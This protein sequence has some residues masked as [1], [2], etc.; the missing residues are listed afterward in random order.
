MRILAINGG[1]TAGYAAVLLL[2]Q[3][4]QRI[5]TPCHRAFDL[6]AGVSTGSIVAAALGLG[7]PASALATLYRTK[8]PSIFKKPFW[9]PWRWYVGQP[10]YRTSRLT[11]VLSRTFGTQTMARMQT[12]VMVLA[13][14][15]A[16]RQGPQ[17]WKSWRKDL[18]TTAL[19][20]IIAASCAAPT[21]FKP[22]CMGLDVF[23]DGGICATNPSACALAEAMRFGA[24]IADVSL[25]NIQFGGKNSPRSS[26][27]AASRWS[28]AGWATRLPRLM[29]D[30][31]A[32]IAEYQCAQALGDRYLNCPFFNSEELDHWDGQYQC[33]I[34]NN[35]LRYWLLNSDRILAT[36]N[37]S[38]R[39]HR[40]Q[41]L[42]DT[43]SLTALEDRTKVTTKNTAFEVTRRMDLNA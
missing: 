13:T 14:Q 22:H 25:V 8:I 37:T 40:P 29:L 38:S 5:G 18:N 36:M 3:L 20:D 28:I 12:A 19:T 6:I 1:G 30:A 34:E 10:K 9:P 33:N 7:M 15:I 41:H 27:R 2:E 23:V 17:V 16:P 42:V 24:N 43:E 26:H 35:V 11:E 31:N 32:A 4:E 21:Y 39:E